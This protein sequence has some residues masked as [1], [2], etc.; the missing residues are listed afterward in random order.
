MNLCDVHTLSDIKV[1]TNVGLRAPSEAKGVCS[2]G[3]GPLG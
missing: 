3:E 2:K 1:G